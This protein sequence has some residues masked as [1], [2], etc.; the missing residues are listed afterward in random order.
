MPPPDLSQVTLAVLAGGAGSRMGRP[1]SLLTVG[2]RPI[3]AYLLERLDWPGPTMLVTSPGRD[4]PPG[5]ERFDSEVRDEVE[6]EGPLRGVYTALTHA[7]T[8]VVTFIG[9]DMPM[10]ERADLAWFVAELAARRT[11]AGLMGTRAGGAVEPLPCSMRPALALGI[12]SDHL[13]SG[14]RSL[15]GLAKGGDVQLVDAGP[16]PQR[17]WTNVNTPEEWERFERELRGEH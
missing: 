3:L 11:A 4:R 5:A 2:N 7:T 10:V 16:L 8:R 14:R 17:V 1:K 9:V 13:A 6:D 12:V 15:H